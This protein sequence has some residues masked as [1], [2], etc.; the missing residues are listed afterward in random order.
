MI[1]S[2]RLN[3]SERARLVIFPVRLDRCFSGLGATSKCKVDC[4]ESAKESRF[5]D[6]LS[7]TQFVSD[8]G[9]RSEV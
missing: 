9:K 3:E 1:F 2:K 5:R 6:L 7:L 4:E 8:P